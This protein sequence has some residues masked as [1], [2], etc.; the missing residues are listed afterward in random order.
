MIIGDNLGCHTLA[1]MNTSF[2]SGIV[3]RYCKAKY[4]DIC[5]EHK[6][7]GG[8]EDDYDPEPWTPQ[9]YDEKVVLAEENCPSIE[10]DGVKR[11]C[12]FNF[13]SSYHCIGQMPP[14]L[15]H[16]WFEGVFGYDIQFYIEY[17]IVKEKCITIEHFNDKIRKIKL[18]SRDG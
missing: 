10:T 16:D 12:C 13:L 5:K 9:D 15:G 6:A 4:K 14:C 11:N 7:Y 18:S 1:E 2:S 8:C 3:C 17:L